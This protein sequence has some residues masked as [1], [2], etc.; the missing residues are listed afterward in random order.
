MATTALGIAPDSTGAGVDPLTHRRVIASHWNNVGV[1]SGLKCSGRSDLSYSLSAGVCVTQRSGSDG[2]CEAY[3][4]G[5]TVATKAGDASNPRYDLVYVKSG[6]PTQGDADNH[7]TAGVVQGTPSASPTVPGAPAG[8]TAVD[9][10]LVPAGMTATTAGTSTGEVSYA[11]PYGASLGLLAQTVDNNQ[12]EA[13]DHG[14]SPRQEHPISFYVPTRR[15]VELEFYVTMTKTDTVAA[16][17]ASI[18][19]GF[20]LDGKLLETAGGEVSVEGT[21]QTFR[22]SAY[23]TVGRGTHTVMTGTKLQGGSVK[24]LA[25]KIGNLYYKPRT[26]SVWDR[27]LAN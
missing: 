4:P 6:D 27:G 24:F 3:F 19:L 5:G 8:A 9:T 13:F 26:F 1:V 16:S 25:G 2:M 23:V 11:I 20:Y 21:Y 7:V 14:G 10:I 18:W 15:L 17:E 22:T 12:G